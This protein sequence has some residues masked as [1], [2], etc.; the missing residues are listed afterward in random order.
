[1]QGFKAMLSSYLTSLDLE[2]SRQD[3]MSGGFMAGK[4]LICEDYLA[5]RAAIQEEQRMR[6]SVN[7]QI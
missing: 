6:R 2:F 5:Q 4:E 7:K 1:M 3:L